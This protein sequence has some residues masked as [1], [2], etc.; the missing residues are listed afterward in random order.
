MQAFKWL[1]AVAMFVVSPALF[2]A[3]SNDVTVSHFEPLQRLSI[4]A[5]GNTADVSQQKVQQGTPVTLSFDAL[6]RSFN[7]Q[8]EPNNNILMTADAVSAYRGRLAD[9]P[10]SWA[11]IVVFNGVPRGMFWD[12]AEMF[13]IEAPGDS[14]LATD[15]P[16]IYRLADAVVLPGTMTCG[17]ATLSGNGAMVYNQ[18]VGEL[19]T[20]I[21]QAPGAVSEITMGAIGDYEF[22]NSKGGDAPAAAAI[23]DR[24]NRVDGI[25]SEQVGVQIN[26]QLP[27]TFSDSAADPFSDTSD[28]STLLNELAVYR[29][30]TPAQNATGLTHLYTG[31]SFPTSTVG[32]A[33]LDELCD[34]FAGAGLSE[35]TN[36][37]AFDSLVAA[38]E[39]GH[40]FGAN[41]DGDPDPNSSCPSE[42]D[43]VYIMAPS[44]TGLDQFS[45]CSIAVMRAAA[46]AAASCVTAI[47][48][49]DVSIGLNS[50]LSTVLLGANTVLTYDV[51]SNGTLQAGNVIADF[52]LPNNFALDSVSTSVG[53]CG[54][55][56]GTINCV[57][58]DIPGVTTRTITITTTPTSVGAGTLSATVATA[59]VDERPSNNQ[60]IVPLTVLPAVDLVVNAPS[61]ATVLVNGITS[62]NATLENRS[63]I[64]ATGVALSISLSNG[65]QAN[66]A[67]W[68]LGTCTITL[69][70]VDCV[71]AD[72]AAQSSATLNID[73]RGISGGSKNF[74]V[75]LSSIEAEANPG[76]NSADGSVR[77]NDPEEDDEGGGSTG[78]M[79]LFLL[80]LTALLTRRR[81]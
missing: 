18:L 47:P 57:L 21:A 26:V 42:P 61:F 60:E 45:D 53:T 16:I 34:N 76:N 68:S 29:F 52:T 11:R 5:A 2:A 6:G 22:T 78:P 3:G 54:S 9:H 30:D 1:S 38:H 65:L 49:V 64:D 14:Q 25:Y 63:V 66:A 36:N 73:V 39:I 77:V 75:S 28:P 72:F 35:G 23:T 15:S 69:Q 44:V 4:R 27:E 50:P 19:D 74:T 67:S 20:A 7:L 24:L 56:A 31:R 81:Q 33:Y 37:A 48:A 55:G 51:S 46:A 43:D 32:I 59:D 10:A 8:L 12:G 41:H 71:A 80:T 13:S 79:L 17:T 62:V 40:N 70:Q 58:G